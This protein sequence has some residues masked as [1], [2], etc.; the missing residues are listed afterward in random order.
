MSSNELAGLLPL[1]LLALVFWFLIMR[2]ARKRQ[3]EAQNTQRSLEVGARVM[4][5][6]GIFGDIDSL[7]DET[8]ELEIAPDTFITV[9]RQAVARVIPEEEQDEPL[10]DEYGDD[11]ADND[12][13][14][15]VHDDGEPGTT[16]SVRREKDG[17]E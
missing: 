12:S 1:V 10:A 14:E 13:D 15:D 16:T 9:L 17:S 4:L 11:G 2:P 5:T 3:R 6:S 8:L 7:D